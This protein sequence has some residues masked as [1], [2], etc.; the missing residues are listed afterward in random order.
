[1]ANVT[2]EETENLVQALESKDATADERRMY[3]R[4]VLRVLEHQASAAAVILG[5]IARAL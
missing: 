3:L 1:M 2:S 5:R 4:A